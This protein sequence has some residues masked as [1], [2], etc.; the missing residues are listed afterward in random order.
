MSAEELQFPDLVWKE[1]SQM[2]A[3]EVAIDL[4]PEEYRGQWH[5]PI[6]SFTQRWLSKQKGQKRA[7]LW[8]WGTMSVNSVSRHPET[9]GPTW[10]DF[11][12]GFGTG[13]KFIDELSHHLTS[14]FGGHAG[15]TE[16]VNARKDDGWAAICHVE[17]GKVWRPEDSIT[18]TPARGVTP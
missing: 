14:K 10:A 4:I 13:A 11:I 7:T 2:P 3:I 17:Q 18:W 6:Y 8:M 1:G 12:I 5:N 16:Y 15:I 9:G